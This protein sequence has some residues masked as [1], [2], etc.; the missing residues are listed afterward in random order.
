MTQQEETP[1]INTPHSDNDDI[2]QPLDFQPAE[3][4]A[5]P[6]PWKPSPVQIGLSLALLVTVLVM[7]Y[8]FA[9]KSLYIRTNSDYPQISVDGLMTLA[10]GERFM[11]LKGDH[12]IH[13]EAEGYY[14]LDTTLTITTEPNQY[15]DL[16]LLPLPGHLSINSPVSAQVSIDNIPVGTTDEVIKNI[17]AGEHSVSFSADRYQPLEM[18]LIIEGRNK[19]QSIDLNLQPNWAEISV[20]TTPA[21]ATL[22]VDDHPVGQTPLTAELLAGKRNIIVKLAG[23][24]PWRQTLRVTPQENKT[25]P[26]IRLFKADGLV[27]VLS[28]PKGASVTVN[29]Q[30]RGKTPVDISLS[31]GTNY[32]FTLFKDGYQPLHRRLKIESGKEAGLNVKLTPNLGKIA[33]SATPSDALLYVDDRL[34]G[35]ANQTLTLPVRKHTVRITKD[36]YADHSEVILPQ[37]KL[38]QKLAVK[39]LTDEEYKWKNIKPVIKTTSNQTLLLFKPDATFT[40]GASRREQGRR[41]NEA[42]RNIKLDRPFYLSQHLVTNADFRKFDRFHSSG[43]VKGNSLNGESYPAVNISWQKA[44]LYCNWLSEQE[45]LPPFYQVT[46]GVVSGFNPEAGGYRMPT[47]AEWAWSARLKDGTMMKYAWGKQLPPSAGS[48][49]LGDRRAAALLGNI[50]TNYDD[51]YPVSSPIGKFPANHRK[52]YDFSGNVA[53]WINDYYGIKTGLSLKS[54]VNPLG[55]EKGDFHV[56]RGS[57][58]A[59]ATMT[60]LRLSFRD[61]SNDARNDV[62]FRLARFID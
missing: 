15:H 46:G 50:L 12:K 22:I 62:G 26:D 5:P 20:N 25:L 27:E 10:I 23:H 2:I 47:E 29:G 42:Q 1:N 51:G 43:H 33:I 38:D 57:S 48:A 56:I 61:Y 49:N 16:E 9:A 37:Q 53:E 60:D 6:A 55:P 44:A 45:K 40:M 14:P 30:F 7:S 18:P 52:L 19:E 35:R 39:L 21:G 41:A 3:A 36:G 13:I 24:K 32:Q 11:L 58:W 4:D 28:S 59:H 8:L 34:M 31:P 17:D 54:E